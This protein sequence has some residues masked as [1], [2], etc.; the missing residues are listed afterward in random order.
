[1]PAFVP[2]FELTVF[3]AASYG[4]TFLYESKLWPLKQAEN[5]M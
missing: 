2:V 5:Q 1:M 4:I 3:F